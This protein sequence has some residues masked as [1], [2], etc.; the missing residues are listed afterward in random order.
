MRNP[1][2]VHGCPVTWELLCFP[3]RRSGGWAV[4]SRGACPGSHPQDAGCRFPT[5]TCSSLWCLGTG[6]RPSP[7]SSSAGDTGMGD[8]LR[9]GLPMPT[10]SP[11][12]PDG[13]VD[14]GWRELLC[15]VHAHRIWAQWRF[16]LMERS[17]ECPVHM[18]NV[19][20][21]V[22]PTDMHENVL[23]AEPVSSRE[24]RGWAREELS[25]RP[26]VSQSCLVEGTLGRNRWCSE[27]A[28]REFK[29]CAVPSSTPPNSS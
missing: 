18:K 29:K 17:R 14:R 19:P 13:Q 22:V 28:W 8:Q 24:C 15:G 16:A 6:D 12:V 26:G 7:G 23:G 9:T 11:L 10:R 5:S 27:V 3:F 1:V 21:L 2:D 4:K 25:G 20:V